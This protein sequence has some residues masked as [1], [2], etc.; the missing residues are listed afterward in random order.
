MNKLVSI[1]L[2]CY[3]G[4][5]FLS[6]AIE[7]VISQTYQHWELIIVNDC[8]TDNTLKIAESFAD[9]DK[10]I[11]VYTNEIN[12]KLPKSLNVGF[13]Y[14]KGDYFTWTSD[15][16]YYRPTALEEMVSFL[17]KEQE[18]VMV[19]C[20]YEIINEKGEIQ[21]TIEINPTF[22]N[23]L[24]NNPCGACF[25]YRKEI[26]EK[27][28]KYDENK[29]LVED[30]DYW[31]RIGLEGK[32]CPLHKKLYVYRYHTQSLTSTRSQEIINLAQVQSFT[33]LDKYIQ[34]YQYLSKEKEIK[35]LILYRAVLGLEEN[36]TKE[37]MNKLMSMG[38]SNA[39][40]KLYKT[41]YKQKK[42]G[43]YIEAMKHLG[44]LYKIKSSLF[45]NK[46]KTISSC[47]DKYR[48]ALT[49]IANYTINENGIVVSS[50]EQR[51]YPEV[52]GYYIPTLL[53]WGLK[54]QALKYVNYLLTIQNDDG[55]WNEP[56]GTYKYTFD[57]GQ[58]LKGLYEFI[59]EDVKYKEAFLKG[60][61][62]IVA[63]QRE[64]EA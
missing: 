4:E 25:L 43:V 51:I 36:S 40:Y 5:K 54:E 8:S 29:F 33:F 22:I 30:Y 62:Y 18:A 23:L 20:D 24:Q 2:P 31:L 39:L 19:C 38:N 6:Q 9:K 63:Q 13:S 50:L 52:T 59:D 12:L 10:R 56:S 27:V 15:D 1:V 48:L 7:S 60:C 61:D 34:K 37:Y 45:K 42:N 32:I 49:W 57:T 53:R 64:M 58:I 17:E 55:S 44:L 21:Q 11:C 26:A 28:G 14:A 35:E 16:N 46:Q 47:L 41:A 3:N